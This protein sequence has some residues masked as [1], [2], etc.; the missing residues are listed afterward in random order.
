M[1]SAHE[2]FGEFF[3]EMRH[4]T[5]LTLR[6]FCLKH[7]L[8][9]GNISRLE[10]GMAAPPS[11]HKILEKYASFLGIQKN[12]DEWYELF[13]LAAAC[14]GK[15]PPDVMS[16]KQLVE[17]LPLVFRTIRAKRLNSKELDKLAELIRKA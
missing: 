6:Q 17:K 9:P 2:K 3:K 15:L 13:D 7:D 14:S 16:D 11:S 4:K 12:S 5:G 1:A 10:R 8:D